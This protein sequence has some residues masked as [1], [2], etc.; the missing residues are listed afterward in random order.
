VEGTTDIRRLNEPQ[1]PFVFTVVLVPGS[2]RWREILGHVLAA[3]TSSTCGHGHGHAVIIA[4]Q[5]HTCFYI[6]KKGKS[7]E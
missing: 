3:G 5:G 6:E 4:V 7:A 1:I 2:E